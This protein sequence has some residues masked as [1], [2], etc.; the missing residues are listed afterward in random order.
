MEAIP[1]ILQVEATTTLIQEL[2][3]TSVHQDLEKIDVASKMIE[4]I[5]KSSSNSIKID[6][7]EAS[8]YLIEQLFQCEEHQYTPDGKLILSTIAF[9]D[10]DLK[11]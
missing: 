5:A 7:V 8:Q 6:S 1:S 4:K 9:T 3:E 2:I 11:F 10:I